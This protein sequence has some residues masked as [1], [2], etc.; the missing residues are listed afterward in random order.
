[1]EQCDEVMHRV[2]VLFLDVSHLLFCRGDG[3]AKY[4]SLLTKTRLSSL[5]LCAKIRQGIRWKTFWGRNLLVTTSVMWD[6]F[7]TTVVKGALTPP[8]FSTMVVH[9]IPLVGRQLTRAPKETIDKTRP[10]TLLLLPLLLRK[11][12]CVWPAPSQA[13]A[14]AA[15]EEARRKAEEDAALAKAAQEALERE[16][17]GEEGEEGG[18]PGD[19]G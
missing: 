5:K 1:M 6:H 17:N 15:A 16:E 2:H 13:E 7:R 9:I 18:E 14:A 12:T 11:L 10:S 3:R 4:H 19:G 8:F